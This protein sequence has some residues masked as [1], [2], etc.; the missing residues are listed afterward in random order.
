MLQ[1]RSL[2]RKIRRKILIQANQ[3][4]SNQVVVVQVL[5]VLFAKR[6]NHVML[7]RT[8]PC[9]IPA[10][11]TIFRDSNDVSFALSQHH[12]YL[13]RV[14]DWNATLLDRGNGAQTS[15]LMWWYMHA[16]GENDPDWRMY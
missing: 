16:R 8:Q 13:H 4:Q 3:N 12:H 11:N 15:D 9:G 6:K 14:N 5:L 10:G 2:R 7:L 1:A